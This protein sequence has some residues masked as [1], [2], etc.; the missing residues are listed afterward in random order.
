MKSSSTR[1]L[2]NPY[3]SVL[4]AVVHGRGKRATELGELAA[5]ASLAFDADRRTLYVDMVLAALEPG[6]RRKV[7]AIMVQKHE[8]QSEYAR[9]YF[10][11]GLA[12]G[13]AEG[14]LRVIEA[15]GFTVPE[16]L[17]QRVRACRDIPTLDAWL[18]RAAT[19]PDVAEL[20]G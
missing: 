16:E 7:E 13:K 3:L 1:A 10:G 9:R 5:E 4:S 11:Q 6:A 8:Y 18:A 12:E 20:F 14:V 15:R 19:L 17:A 2:D